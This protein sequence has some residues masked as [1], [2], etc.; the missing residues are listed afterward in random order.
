MRNSVVIF[1]FGV[2]FPILAKSTRLHEEARS[3]SRCN[4]SGEKN[5]PSG[6]IAS[7][8]N[9]IEV[10]VAI[11]VHL[12]F[13]VHYVCPENADATISPPI[14]A[15]L[16]VEKPTLGGSFGPSLPVAP[17]PYGIDRRQKRRMK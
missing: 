4:V 15:N 12:G 6:Q 1:C 3:L 10:K 9:G 2:S 11:R 8:Q 14:S 13:R 7:F 16:I 5:G 17:I